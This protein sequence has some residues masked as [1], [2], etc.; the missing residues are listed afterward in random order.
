MSRQEVE[1]I[2]EDSSDE[3]EIDSE[4]T[5]LDD[6]VDFFTYKAKADKVFAKHGT[7]VNIQKKYEPF[8]NY[9]KIKFDFEGKEYT[10]SE[11][12]YHSNKF[13]DEW[14]REEIRNAPTPNN[15]SKALGNLKAGQWDKQ[16]VRDIIKEAK[17]RKI[18]MRSD[19][20]KIKQDIMYK[21]VTEKFKNKQLRKLLKDTGNKIIRECSPYDREWGIF[22]DGT[23]KNMLGIIL[24]R[25]RS[26]ISD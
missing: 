10:S 20:D 17:S 3:E 9:Y 23:G 8:S 4:D 18:K 25:V 26:E 21:I 11:H 15:N 14:Y 7:K 16:E 6:C 5:N 24:M 2:F 1:I 22:K 13:E 19:W 12:P